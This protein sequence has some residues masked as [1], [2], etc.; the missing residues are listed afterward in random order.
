[1]CCSQTACALCSTMPYR[2]HHRC[3][4]CY[5][6]AA[7][8]NLACQLQQRCDCSFTIKRMLGVRNQPTMKQSSILNY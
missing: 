4:D 6:R 1:M 2:D 3:S 5:C 8:G 7:L